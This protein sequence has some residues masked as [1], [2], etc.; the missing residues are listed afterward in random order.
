MA[1]PKK[2]PALTEA[3]R[4]RFY[5]LQSEVHFED[6]D[7]DKLAAWIVARAELRFEE[8]GLALTWEEFADLLPHVEALLGELVRLGAL[9]SLPKSGTWLP[10]RATDAEAQTIDNDP[11]D[12]MVSAALSRLATAMTGPK[13]ARSKK[14]RSKRR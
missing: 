13:R 11:A 7:V 8:E 1:K 6:L 9:R 3:F 2:P 5:K 14:P 12:T 10:A 4:K